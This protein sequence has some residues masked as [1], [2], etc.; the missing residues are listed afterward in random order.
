VNVLE[1]LE[2]VQKGESG[3]YMWLGMSRLPQCVAR[4]EAEW[5]A[6]G[7]NHCVLLPEDTGLEQ[8]CLRPAPRRGWH[9]LRSARGELTC[10]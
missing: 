1:S 8:V 3:K 7:S 4:L 2:V 6:P 5:A 10:A 9:T